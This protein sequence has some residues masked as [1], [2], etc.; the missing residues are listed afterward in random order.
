MLKDATLDDDENTYSP[1]IIEMNGHSIK[2]DITAGYDLTLNNGTVEG[3]VRVET[4]NEN[5][6][7]VMTAPSE[8]DAAITGDLE[9][10][11]GSADITVN[12]R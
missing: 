2:S 1:L 11:K 6:K 5:G 8:A 12:F 10:I 3:N 9:I 4:T 7:F